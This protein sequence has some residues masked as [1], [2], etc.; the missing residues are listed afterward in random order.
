M[1]VTGQ[2]GKTYTLKTSALLLESELH[3]R[4]RTKRLSAYGRFSLGGRMQ[5]TLFVI[6][7]IAFI[8]QL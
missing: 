2:A 5:T 3:L 6:A 8:P 4:L 7:F 1:P